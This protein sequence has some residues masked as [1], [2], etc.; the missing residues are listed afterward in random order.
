MGALEIDGARVVGRAQAATQSK[1]QSRV[2]LWHRCRPVAPAVTLIQRH[3]DRLLNREAG[4]KVLFN[5]SMP[6]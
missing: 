5:F 1:K 2:N 4:F 6:L 3:R